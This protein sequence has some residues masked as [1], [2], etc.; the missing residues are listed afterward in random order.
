VREFSISY[1]LLSIEHPVRDFELARMLNDSDE[2]VDFSG[3]QFTG[4]NNGIKQINN[5]FTKY[6]FLRSTSAFLQM[7]LEKRRPIPYSINID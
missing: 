4:S 6:L 7:T 2:F 1:V 3:S 5:N